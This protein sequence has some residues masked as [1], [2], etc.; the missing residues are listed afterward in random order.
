MVKN[1]VASLETSQP[2]SSAQT[3]QIETAINGRFN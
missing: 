3:R 2:D 1:Q